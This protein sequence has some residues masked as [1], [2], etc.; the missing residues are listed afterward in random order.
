MDKELEDGLRVFVPGDSDKSERFCSSPEQGDEPAPVSRRRLKTLLGRL[1]RHPRLLAQIEAI[2][3]IA[4]AGGGLQ[5][6]TADEVEAFIVEAT[7]KLGNQTLTHWAEA[8]QEHAIEDCKKEH[9]DARLKKTVLSWWCMFGKIT[10]TEHILQTRLK[11]PC[12]AWCKRNAQTMAQLRVL[13]FNHCW[14]ELWPLP[15]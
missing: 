9:P 13:R 10:L 3:A 8:A 5:M 2:A 7:R 6:W 4:D 14:H 11:L 12:A 15:A 1:A